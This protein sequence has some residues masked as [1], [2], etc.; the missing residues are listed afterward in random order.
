MPR[1]THTPGKFRVLVGN[2]AGAT[3]PSQNG[4]LGKPTRT[5]SGYEV[6]PLY[7][8]GNSGNGMNLNGTSL[9]GNISTASPARATASFDVASATLTPTAYFFVNTY[10]LGNFNLTFSGSPALSAPIVL[11]GI[12]SGANANAT[13][14]AVE[15]AIDGNATLAALFETTVQNDTPVVGKARVAIVGKKT[16]TLLNA[17]NITTTVPGAADYQILNASFTAG[18]SVTTRNMS[19]GTNPS[20]TLTIG[21]VTFDIFASLAVDP[22]INPAPFPALLNSLANRQAIATNLAASISRIPQFA[23]TAA[24]TTVSI[25][26]PAGP[27]GGTYPFYAEQGFAI[28]STFTPNSGYFAVGAPTIV[29]PILT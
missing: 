14:A 8:S 28:L 6:Q 29:G 3:D 18:P 25:T 13:A 2:F 21:D 24:G 27:D 17:V 5:M 9:A 4:I 11:V 15:A 22:A 1:I 7:F 12:A 10:A 20:P 19:G 26:G 23:A 16:G